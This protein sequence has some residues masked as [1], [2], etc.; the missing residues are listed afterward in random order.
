MGSSRRRK[1]GRV[2]ADKPSGLP[3]TRRAIWL[4]ENA[5][6][7]E[8]YNAFIAEHGLFSDAFRPF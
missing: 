2:R 4:A 3:D 1:A 6:A 8:Y 5:P 7:I